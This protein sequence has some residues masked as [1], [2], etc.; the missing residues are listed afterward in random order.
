MKS[1]HVTISSINVV[2]AV[3]KF[4]PI[5]ANY[6]HKVIV[7][8]EDDEAIRKKNETLLSGL[9]FEF[10]GP[11]KRKEWFKERFGSSYEKYASVIPERCHA[12]TS[13][14]F[15]VAY[16]ENPDFVIELD[17]DV[18]AFEGYN[19]ID[20]H[21]DN[22]F[23]Q[24]GITVSSKCKWYNTLENLELS[25]STPIFPRGH[26]YAPETRKENYDWINRRNKC[27][28]NMGLWAGNPD[29]DALTIL[30]NGGLDSK[31]S[32][33]ALNYKRDKVIV[34][35]GTYFAICSMN[36]SFVPKIIPAFYQ[37]YMNFMGIDRFDD[38]WSGIFLKKIADHLGDRICLGRPL[39]YHDKRPRSVF[40]DLKKELEGMI[41][42]EILW[43]IV[44]SLNLE[45][46]TYWDSYSSLIQGLEKN[47]SKLQNKLHQ[48]FL[49][50]QTQKM[51]LWL[52]IIDKIV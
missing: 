27:V 7:I 46:K 40:D 39:I 9:N 48:K 47:L 5:F 41:I 16:E 37:L 44:D 22:L 18:F 15:L 3:K 42:N 35:R 34:D 13:F 29:L 11:R 52:K 8:D 31:C 25:S 50:V 19:I 28:L 26:P 10:Y 2:N 33:K 36:T 17:D 23:N 14:G 24:R 21:F 38:I 43:K 20:N 4:K 1:V 6:E 49:S 30:Y 51:L 45:G 12:E 32:I